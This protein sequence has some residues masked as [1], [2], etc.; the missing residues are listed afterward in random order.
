MT[1][2]ILNLMSVEELN[3]LFMSLYCIRKNYIYI[4]PNKIS[5]VFLLSVNY[6]IVNI[7]IYI[8]MQF[9]YSC[10]YVNFWPHHC[11]G[12]LDKCSSRWKIPHGICARNKGLDNV[13]EKALVKIAC[14]FGMFLMLSWWVFVCCLLPAVFEI[15]SSYSW[16]SVVW[17]FRN[18]LEPANLWLK[19]WTHRSL[20]N[21]Y[22]LFQKRCE[23]VR[24]L[25][26][27]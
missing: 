27:S 17:K 4:S 14:H 5:Y 23:T 21:F 2:G 11:W 18:Y 20:R 12:W 3:L 15:L 16:H 9:L 8:F 22:G 7:H 26:R 10:N 13:V 1:R 25:L 24:S 19:I 6:I